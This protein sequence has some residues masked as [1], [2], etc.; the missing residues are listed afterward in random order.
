M[1]KSLFETIQISQRFSD[2]AFKLLISLMMVCLAISVMQF[3][4]RLAYGRNW[5]GWY[6]PVITWL[7]SIE[8]MLTKGKLKELDTNPRLLYHASE[9][10]IFAILLK[11]FHYV[12]VGPDQLWID[13]PSWQQNFINFFE[14]DYL[15]VLVMLFIIWLLSGSLIDD[16]DELQIEMT[17]LKWEL[18]KLDNNRQAARQRMVEKI[19]TAGGFMVFVTLMTRLDLQVFWGESPAS[20]AS[21][22]NVLV[23][24]L[25]TLVF[26][27]VTQFSLLRGRW[28]WNKTP[29][30]PEIGRNWLKFSLIFFAILAAIAFILPTRYTFGL[31][32]VLQIMFNFLTQVLIFLFTLLTFPCA[33]LLSLLGLRS[34]QT[35]SLPPIQPPNLNTLQPSGPPSALWELIKSILFWAIFIGI[36]SFAFINFLRQHPGI[37]KRL[38]RIPGF[39]WLFDTLKSLWTWI[40]GVNQQIAATISSGWQRIFRSGSRAMRE[41][42]QKYFN[43]RNLSPRQQVIF[44]YL[45]LL[46]RSKKSGIER[47]PYQTPSQFATELEQFVP[48]VEQDIHH[49]TETFVEARYSS[50]SIGSEHTSAVQRLWR[51]I[52]QRLKPQ[53]PAD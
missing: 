17:D 41:N 25:L 12:I 35:Q 19:F 31:L 22:A 50:H 44:Y 39:H 3:G 26:L 33:W 27:S 2:W 21:I 47:K 49:M 9:W 36:V 42:A 29:I 13:L 40:R 4:D 38:L 48:E 20:Q 11:V 24:F 51:R 37:A 1:K 46:D 14:G 6:L 32:E 52:V 30:S 15:P 53:K 45:R 16:L 18:G 23:Y 34:T 43:F 7:V 10:I 28:F 5:S 8:A